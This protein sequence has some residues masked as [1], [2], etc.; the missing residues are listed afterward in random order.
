MPK[1]I[2]LYGGS[3]DPPGIHHRLIAIKIA[4]MFDEVVVIPCG[5][6]TDGKRT[7]NRTPVKFREWM[8]QK[9]FE[10]LD[11]V[12][13][14]FSDLYRANQAFEKTWELVERY[15]PAGEVWVVVGADL[16]KK[17][18]NGRSQIHDWSKG[19]ELWQNARFAVVGRSGIHLTSKDLPPNRRLVAA[20]SGSSTDIRDRVKANQSIEGLVVPAVEHFIRLHGIYR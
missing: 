2:A 6:R 9:T 7:V 12:R 16:V 19:E 5:F 1:R 17:D 10:G 3:F 18:A 14:D 4:Q 13:C 20:M 11:H 15:N 8:V